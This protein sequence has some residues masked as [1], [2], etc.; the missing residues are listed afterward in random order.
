LKICQCDTSFFPFSIRPLWTLLYEHFPLTLPQP[1]KQL[2]PPWWRFRE[3]LINK[4]PSVILLLP[5]V[6]FWMRYGCGILLNLSGNERGIGATIICVSL[7]LWN[8]S[9]PPLCLLLPLLRDELND[10]PD[11]LRNHIR[12]NPKWY[13]SLCDLWELHRGVPLV[14]PWLFLCN[15]AVPIAALFLYSLCFLFFGPFSLH[16]SPEKMIWFIRNY[17]HLPVFSFSRLSR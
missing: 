15:M 12:R 10:N 7:L 11:T 14:S 4:P 8:R 3:T 9:I 5:M 2:V 17:I 16:Q 13:A 1:A 6:A